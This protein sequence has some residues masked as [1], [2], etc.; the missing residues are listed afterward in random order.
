MLVVIIV[1]VL[2]FVLL[3]NSLLGNLFNNNNNNKTQETMQKE[4]TINQEQESQN[5]ISQQ[6]ESQLQSKD[7]VEGTGALATTGKEITVNYT[8]TFSDG[9]VFDSS[10][11]RAPF[12][13]TLGANMVIKGWDIGVEGMKVGGKRILII[14][15]QLGYGE[16]DY[17]PIPGNSTLTFEIE[18][19]EVK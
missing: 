19:L 7:I 11:G 13:F 1:I 18:L 14:P 10:I 2:V 3:G 8:G 16:K 17:G 15:P 12:T 9:K 5:I 4:D 6:G